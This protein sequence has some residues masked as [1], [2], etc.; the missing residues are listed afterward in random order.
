MHFKFNLHSKDFS[1]GCNHCPKVWA[2]WQFIT[3][4]L[5]NLKKVYPHRYHI[6]FRLWIYTRKRVA[7]FDLFWSKENE[8][9]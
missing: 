2:W 9:T 4:D 7:H 1:E 3:V 8:N 5:L 6:Y